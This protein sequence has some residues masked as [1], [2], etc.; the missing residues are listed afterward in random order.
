MRF[1]SKIVKV[2]REHTQ[3]LEEVSKAMCKHRAGL[4][5]RKVSILRKDAGPGLVRMSG[6]R[7][8]SWGDCC[9]CREQAS[10]HNP[11]LSHACWAGYIHLP[12]L[13]YSIHQDTA[14]PLYKHFWIG[15]VS[16]FYTN[17]DFCFSMVHK[18]IVCLTIV[19]IN[20]NGQGSWASI[21]L[22]VKCGR[23]YLAH[24]IHKRN[25]IRQHEM[26]YMPKKE[27]MGIIIKHSIV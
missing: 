15:D 21:S 14:S 9:E 27:N 17:H 19:G 10:F 12:N 13:Q 16:Y 18:I 7:E 6:M 4:W 1:G 25:K 24:K 20:F 11:E 3:R 22:H 8:K 5:T 26:T 2:R 23:W